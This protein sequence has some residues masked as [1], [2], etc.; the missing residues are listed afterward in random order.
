MDQTRNNNSLYSRQNNDAVEE[1]DAQMR[2]LTANDNNGAPRGNNENHSIAS[3]SEYGEDSDE[4]PTL[5]ADKKPVKELIG[6]EIF[7]FIPDD[8]PEARQKMANKV[9]NV[10]EYC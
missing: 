9:A 2:R 3:I 5:I 7:A 10:K 8:L 1:L 4:I 6:A